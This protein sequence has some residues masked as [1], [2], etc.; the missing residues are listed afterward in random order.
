MLTLLCGCDASRPD[1]PDKDERSGRSQSTEKVV[2][3]GDFTGRRS[4]SVPAE[5]GTP[6][7]ALASAYFD[8]ATGIPTALKAKAGCAPCRALEIVIYPTRANAQLQDSKKPLN[9]DA[10]SLSNGIAADP[11]PVQFSGPQPTVE[12]LR[13][14]SFDI[15]S[16]L[17][18]PALAKSIEQTRTLLKDL[19]GLE[20]THVTIQ[21]ALPFSSDLRCRVFAKGTRRGAF[22]DF[23]AKGKLVKVNDG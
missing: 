6:P 13:T 20:I 2:T 12:D 9:F 21:R 7:A 23:D 16:D 5:P 15:E 1:D 14:Q 22:V 18:W 4:T 11:A 19:E 8:D 10:Y 17:D 3:K